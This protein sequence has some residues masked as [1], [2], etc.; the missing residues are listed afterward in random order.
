MGPIGTGFEPLDTVLD[1]GFLPG[2]VVLLGGQPGAG[3]T[4]CALQWARNISSQGG[5]SPSPAS[6]TTSRRCSIGSSSRSWPL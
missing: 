5:G 4:I 6:S 2:D 3:K 1:G